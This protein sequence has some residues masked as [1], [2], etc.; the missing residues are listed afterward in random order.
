MVRQRRRRRRPLALEA[1]ITLTVRNAL[2][3]HDRNPRYGEYTLCV[4][5][6]RLRRT[7]R[8]QAAI[9]MRLEQAAA[10]YRLTAQCSRRAA[11]CWTGAEAPIQRL[12]DGD[13]KSVV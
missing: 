11:V 1:N 2:R 8:A 4:R 10:G 3:S 5:S 9:Y 7:G 13:R 6:C 12:C